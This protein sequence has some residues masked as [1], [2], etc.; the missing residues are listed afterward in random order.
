M[1]PIDAKIFAVVL[2]ILAVIVAANLRRSFRTGRIEYG[3]VGLRRLVA[4]RAIN[5][6]SYRAAVSLNIFCLVAFIVGLIQA[7][8]TLIR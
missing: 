1:S 5:V 3:H 7:V 4:D 8:A 6:R 2:T